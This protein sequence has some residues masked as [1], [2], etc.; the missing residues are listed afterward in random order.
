MDQS[1]ME[2]LMEFLKADRAEMR[3]HH[4]KMMSGLKRMNAKLNAWF[5]KSEACL[6]E[7]KE[8][9]PEEPKAVAET[10]EVPEGATGEEAIGVTEDRSRNLRLAV[11]YRGR[12]KTRTKP[13]G[14]LRQV[15]AAA[16]GRPTRRSVPAMRKGGL[17]RG[18]GRM[19]RRSCIKGRSKASRAGKRGMA[20][21]NMERGTPG[22]RTCERRRRT[23][24]ECNSGTRRL[25]KT[26]GNGKR[27][28]IVKSDQRLEAK[29]T[30]HEAI[31]KSLFME[32][33]KLIFESSI[34]PRETGHCGSVGPR[35]SGRGN[36]IAAP[37]RAPAKDNRGGRGS[38]VHPFVEEND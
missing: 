8:P 2:E 9:A 25:S 12:L 22:G 28:R 14:R 11:G 29:R 36:T 27:G 7:E 10:K 31:R 4:E 18:P 26:S 16:V 3:A 23:R 5:G 30:H 37:R 6:E 20:K 15:C 24:P 19:C 33:T 34:G 21:N 35:R 13:D 17:R 32:V 38:G 1:M